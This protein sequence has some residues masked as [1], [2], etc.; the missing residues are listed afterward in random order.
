MTKSGFFNI[1]FPIA[2][3]GVCDFGLVNRRSRPILFQRFIDLLFSS[4]GDQGLDV[5]TRRTL[6]ARASCV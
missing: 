3:R 2:V 5:S 6:V 4:A 1:D